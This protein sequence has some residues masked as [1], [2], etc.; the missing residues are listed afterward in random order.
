MAMDY[1]T[2]VGYSQGTSHQNTK[3]LWDSLLHEQVQNKSLF[4]NLTGKDKA[5]ENSIDESVANYPII[6]KTQLGKE[7]GDQITMGLVKN[8]YTTDGSIGSSNYVLNANAGKTG[9]TQLVDN[10]DTLT[11]YNLKV[12]IAHQRAGVLIQGKMAE[13]RSPYDLR[14]TAKDLLSTSLSKIQDDGLMF[15]LYSGFSPNVF[16][17][18]GHAVAVPTAHPNIIFGKD[19]SALT[20]V[21]QSDVF[22][23]DTLE[24][25]A[26]SMK[27]NN[28]NPCRWEGGE[29]LL[30]IVHPFA[31]KT[32]RAD[33]LY[34]ASVGR[35][36]ERGEGNP[37]FT[38]AEHAWAGL[39]IMQSNKVEVAMNYA[40]LTVSADVI[41]LGAATMGAGIVNTDVRM[42]VVLGANAV[43]RAYGLESY[44]VRRK[45][46]DYENLIGFGGG[47]I[48]GDKRADFAL[49]ADSGTDGA[50]KNQSSA[51]LYTHSPNP[52]SNFSRIWT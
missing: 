27:F 7:Q 13:Q 11:F 25:V 29:D 22:D 43:A 26:V 8:L 47:Y 23:T 50:V 12:K 5:G 33:S 17:E 28:I 21:D 37:L 35:A 45:E 19:K 48:Y 20:G 52:N 24:R 4:K 40:G 51:I 36:R 2:G 6:E 32:L 1:D 41:T 38:G 14:K 9:N 16:R 10:E 18:L 46:D 31:Y 42:N 44:M 49:S 34:Q 15:A 3:K 30:I 39:Y